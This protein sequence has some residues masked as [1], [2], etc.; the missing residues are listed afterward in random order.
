[1]KCRLIQ[2]RRSSNDILF[3]SC[4][5]IVITLLFITLLIQ[6]IQKRLTFVVMYLCILNIERA[7]NFGGNFHVNEL[8]KLISLLVL[9]IF[10]LRKLLTSVDLY[11][12]SG[13]SIA[14]K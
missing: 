6:S 5:G 14:T 13:A 3:H 4:F 7:K 8:L 1:M 12:I 11:Y 10:W 2:Y 9:T